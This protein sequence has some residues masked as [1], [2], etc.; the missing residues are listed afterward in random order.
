MPA[1]L[2]KEQEKLWL[3]EDVSESEVLQMIQPLPNE[4]LRYYTVS[5]AVNKVSNNDP[6]LIEPFE[7]NEGNDKQLILF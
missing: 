6:S 1:I 3:S 7:Y 5:E 4:M 2:L